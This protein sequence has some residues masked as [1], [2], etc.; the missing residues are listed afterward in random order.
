LGQLSEIDANCL[1]DML[2]CCHKG[3]IDVEWGLGN[4]VS[5]STGHIS[6][7]EL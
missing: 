4:T 5:V 3:M 7:L 6:R 2:K 1:L